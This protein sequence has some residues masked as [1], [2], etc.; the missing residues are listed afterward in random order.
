MIFPV[1]AI[2]IISTILWFLLGIF[3]GGYLNFLSGPLTSTFISLFG[4]RVALSLMGDRSQAEYESLIFYS[5]LYAGILFVAKGAAHIISDVSA[6]LYTDLRFGEA[7]SLQNFINGGETLQPTVALHALGAK[8]IIA[9]ITYTA[10]YVVLAVPLASAARASGQG[11]P[12]TRYFNGI[13]RSF[14]PLFCIF[15]L[16]FFLQFFFGLYTALFAI[17]PLIVS[18]GSLAQSQTLPDLT[19]LYILLNAL[20]AFASLLWTY[21]WVWAASAVALESS[22]RST[23]NLPDPDTIRRATETDLR[24]LRKSRE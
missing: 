14:I 17:L 21:S 3:F 20:L 19:D 1:L 23:N 16:S 10:V 11:A 18:I 13:G 22:D 5:L 4:I 9:M 15:G 8:V 2:L 12:D 6:L 24:A 7:V